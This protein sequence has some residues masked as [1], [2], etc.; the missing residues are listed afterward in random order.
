MASPPDPPV[1]PA[2]IKE[3][4]AI[5]R[6]SIRGEAGRPTSGTGMTQPRKTAA[7]PAR[8]LFRGLI[9]PQVGA[10]RSAECRRS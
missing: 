9:T 3:N 4:L 5:T 1:L 7:F 2:G 10:E 8:P 6:H